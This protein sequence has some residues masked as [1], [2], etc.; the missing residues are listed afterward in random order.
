MKLSS[1]TSRN[2]WESNSRAC[3]QHCVIVSECQV[4][5]WPGDAGGMPRAEFCSV[6]VTA[7]ESRTND[8]FC[9][10]T[11]HGKCLNILCKTQPYA[12]TIRSV[13]LRLLP[14]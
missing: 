11:A 8:M 3:Y 12:I 5:I 13:K 1:A 2:I 14:G 10:H 7:C 4:Y 9:I 6:C